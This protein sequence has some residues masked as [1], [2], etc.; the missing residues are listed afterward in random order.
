MEKQKVGMKTSL[1]YT[2]AISYLKALVESMESGRIVVENGENHVSLTPPEN[3]TVK[4]EAKTKKD[5]QKFSLEVSWPVNAGTPLAISD[6]EP[7]PEAVPAAERETAP[8]AAPEAAVEEK[9]EKAKKPE[10]AK[11]KTAAGQKKPK[12]KKKKK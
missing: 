2:E 12:N 1:A 9:K 5:K 8:E 3:V 10:K 11:P 4:I 7:A 6:R